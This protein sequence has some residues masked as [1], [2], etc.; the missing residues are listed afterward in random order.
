[1]C[2]IV[3]FYDPEINDKQAAIG[4]MMATIKH[5]GPSSDGLYTNDEVALGFRRL[6]IIDLR[7]GSQPIY[8]ED[9]TRAIIFNGEIYNFKPLRKELI[10]A[11]HV[12]TTKADTEVLL[13]GYEEWGMADLLKRVRGMFAFLIW[14]DNN[15]TLYGARDFFGIKPMYYSDHDGHLLVGSELK[16]FLAFPG[17]KPVL[18]MEAVKPYLMNQYNDLPETFFKGVYRFPAGHWFEYKN[19]QMD[20]HQYWDAKYLQNNLSFEDTVK[21]INEDLAETVDLYRNADV[22]VGAFLSEGVD[23]SFLTA[24]LDPDDVFSIGFDD[25]TYDEASKAQA[26]AKIND[27]TFY[28]DKVK[29]DEAMH[30]FP[31]MQ[32]HMDEPDANPSIIPLWYLCK[33][34]RRHVTVALSG[35]GADELFAGYV[36]YGMHTHSDTIKAFTAGLKKLPHKTRVHLAHKIKRMPDFPGKVHLYTNLA[37]PSEFYCG[38]SVIYDMDYPTIFTSKDANSVLQPAYRN[39]LTVNGIYQKDFAKVKNADNVKQMQYIDLHHFM[40]ND[41]EQKADKISMA[42]SLEL[43]V[44]YL[45]KKIAELAN[46]IPTKYLVNKHDTKYALRK[47]SEKVLPEAWAKRPKLGFPTPI[48]QWLKEPRFYKQV[49]ALFTADFVNEIFDQKKIVKLLDD[50]YH[51]DGSARRQIWTIY[52]FLVWYKLFFID[53]DETVAKYQRVQPEVAALIEQGKLI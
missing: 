45:D 9:K 48:K 2:G 36:N 35:E 12:F 22:P 39:D 26:L 49:R 11:G 1:M 5:R 6:S 16:S 29:A 53:Y 24:L 42:H 38:Q 28:S 13:H 18:N 47:A 10:A 8:N 43:R 44:P 37:D 19:G 20:I 51:G 4:K 3:A 41:I 52:T 23:S 15:K 17:F 21:K 32:Y 46:S 7:G 31:E 34:A 27:W 30:D 40:L 25:P 33:L 50:N 14:D